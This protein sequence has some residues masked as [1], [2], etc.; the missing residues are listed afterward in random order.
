VGSA[1]LVLL[2]V[3]ATSLLLSA[4]AGAVRPSPSQKAAI[5]A[6]L[7]SEQGDVAIQTISLSHAI[8]GFAS[9]KWGFAVGKLSAYNNSL[10]GLDGGKW[11]V[12]WTREIEQPADGA[13]VYVPTAVVT[14]LFHVR[15]PPVA[16][17]HARLARATEFTTIAKAFR[18]SKLTPYAKSATNLSHVC[19]SKLDPAWSAAVADFPSGSSVYVWFRHGKP[20]FESMMEGGLP[21][22]PWVMLSLASCVGYNPSDFGA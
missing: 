10:L 8:P 15:C 2:A 7:R 9:M 14:E 13:C 16:K 4:A 3:L 17:L 19:V 20:T 6:A 11:K 1:G 12:L 18:K 22:P 21:P 5:V